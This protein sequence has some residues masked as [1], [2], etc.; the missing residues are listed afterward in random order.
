[1]FN[2]AFDGTADASINSPLVGS[3]LITL[4]LDPGSDGTYT[5]A[6]LGGA[7]FEFNFPTAGL[8]YTNADLTTPLADIRI[9]LT[10]SGGEQRLQFSN[11]RA[12]GAG[13]LSGSIDFGNFSNGL[14]FSPPGPGFGG[15]LN[16]FMVLTATDFLFGNYYAS[17][18]VAAVPEP[19]TWLAGSIA[20]LALAAVWR[21]RP[22]AEAAR[23]G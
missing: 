16:Q 19:G 2:V 12:I 11:S 9:R 22:G 8:S 7:T 21:R 13:P 6:A 4:A 23:R 14:T 1:M 3:G 17:R 20:T 15:A 18:T 5:L 10:T